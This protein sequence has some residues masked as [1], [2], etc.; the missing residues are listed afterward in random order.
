ML[1]HSQSAFHGRAGR[2]PHNK[3]YFTTRSLALPGNRCPEALPRLLS[4]KIGGRASGSALPGRARE[5][6]N[7]SPTLSPL[8]LPTLPHS[9]K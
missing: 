1:H 7:N 2:P 5:R 6:G 3:T 8:P 9:A 4:D